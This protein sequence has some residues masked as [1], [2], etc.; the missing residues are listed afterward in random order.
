MFY[1]IINSIVAINILNH[2]SK[3]TRPTRSNQTNNLIH[4]HFNQNIVS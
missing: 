4:T 2:A 1:K 3:S